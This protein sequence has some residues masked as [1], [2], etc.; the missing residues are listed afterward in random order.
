MIYLIRHAESEGNLYRV[1]QGHFDTLLS[2]TGQAQCRALGKRFRAVPLAVVY[3]SDLHRAWAT[4][5]AVARVR[6]TR[7]VADPAL[8]EC[9]LGEAEGESRGDVRHRYP[10]FGRTSLLDLPI[11]GAETR[12]ELRHRALAAMEGIVARHEGKSVAVVSHGGTIQ[13]FLSA[14]FPERTPSIAGNASV[15]TLGH[16]KGVWTVLAEADTSHL[17]ASV[18]SAA[19]LSPEQAASGQPD[20]RFAPIDPVRDLETIRRIGRESW[21]TVLGTLKDYHEPSFLENTRRIARREGFALLCKD[22][23]CVAGML[24][25]DA[26]Q[27][28]GENCGHISLLYLEPEYRRRGL[29]AQLIGRATVVFSRL[30]RP[31]LRLHVAQRNK[32]AIRFYQKHG[33]R[34]ANIPMSFSGQLVMKK[35]IAIPQIT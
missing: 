31:I 3:S 27:T 28:D 6:R 33:F 25:L 22:G 30:G 11:P 12:Q 18:T 19:F 1:I 15:L 2:A 17:D 29:G 21:E 8:R 20:L 32:P 24:L 16:E 10:E 7:L 34:F 13:A 23:E 5:E 26:D 4:A 14:I 35:P 9:C